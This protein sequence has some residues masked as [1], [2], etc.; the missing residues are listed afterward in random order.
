M[1]LVISLVGPTSGD[2]WMRLFSWPLMPTSPG[3]F[4]GQRSMTRG[5]A[6]NPVQFKMTLTSSKMGNAIRFMAKKLLTSTPSLECVFGA[7]GVRDRLCW[8]S[9]LP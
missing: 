6:A 7:D 5:S 1:T 9:N 4:P 2:W 3:V 8:Y